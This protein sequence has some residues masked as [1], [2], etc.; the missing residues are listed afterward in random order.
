MEFRFFFSPKLARFERL[1]LGGRFRLLQMMVRR[2][3]DLFGRQL[4]YG[5][6]EN[7]LGRIVRGHVPVDRFDKARFMPVVHRP[8]PGQILDDF[9]V[10]LAASR[11]V[12]R[13]AEQVGVMPEPPHASSAKPR[14]A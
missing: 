14:G 5:G 6:I 8:K 13:R 2:H 3:H 10:S 9:A 12:R 1:N 4:F 11:R 7:R